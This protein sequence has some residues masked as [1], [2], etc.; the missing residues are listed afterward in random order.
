[1]NKQVPNPEMIRNKNLTWLLNKTRFAFSQARDRIQ[2]PECKKIYELN[3]YQLKFSQIKITVSPSGH[4]R[5]IVCDCGYSEKVKPPIG[6]KKVTTVPWYSSKLKVLSALAGC[7]KPVTSTAL[8]KLTGMNPATTLSVL[9]RQ[10]RCQMASRTPKR[11]VLI[12]QGSAFLWSISPRGLEWLSWAKANN[13]N[14][15]VLWDKF[16]TAHPERKP[17]VIGLPKRK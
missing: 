9:R 14:E 7:D 16:Y 2:C 10:Y 5:S 17:K 3:I 15:S 6:W 12:P 4:I 11:V 8:S 13:V 1:M